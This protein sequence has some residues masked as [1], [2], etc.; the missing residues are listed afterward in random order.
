MGKKTKKSKTISSSVCRV[1]KL[2]NFTLLS[3]SF[4]RSSNLSLASVGL[5]GRV[6]GLPEEWDYSIKGLS[7]ICKE[8]ET[9]IETVLKDLQEWGY[10]KI[11]KL[12][13][14][15]TE[16][17]RIHYVY[18]FYESSE[19]DKT[20]SCTVMAE[21]NMPSNKSKRCRV[22]KTDNFTIVSSLLLRSKAISLKS[23]GLLLRVLS[24]PDDWDYS[25]AGLVFICKEG[26]TAID[27]A[28]KELKNIGYLVVT[29][30]YA[31][32]T[33]SKGIEYVYALL[34]NSITFNEIRFIVDSISINKFLSSAQNAGI[35]RKLYLWIMQ[36]GDG[37]ELVAPA[38]ERA[39]YLNEVRKML[40]AY[41][42][43]VV[44]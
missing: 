44:Q 1:H 37:V 13:P 38:K 12:Y 2:K 42:E 27:S 28:L 32:M 10:L 23:L 31:N 43:I 36:Y 21:G 41:P 24:F 33:A 5:L 29:K 22:N 6:M 34:D 11:S 20:L 15:E 25:V 16:D 30:L 9:A 7:S 19:K 26:K 39:E 35:N 8:G 3:N 40:G 4:L 14:N 18:D 17:G